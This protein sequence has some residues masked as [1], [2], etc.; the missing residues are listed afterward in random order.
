ML[1]WPLSVFF[2]FCCPG[3]AHNVPGDDLTKK[4]LFL[5]EYFDISVGYKSG[6]GDMTDER[7]DLSD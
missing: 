6:V 7:S 1:Q 2:S 4:C 5:P 3:L